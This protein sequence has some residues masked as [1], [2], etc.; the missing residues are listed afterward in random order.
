V[1]IQTIKADKREITGKKSRFL[2]RGGITPANVFGHGIESLALQCD[3]AELQRVLTQAGKT[4][5]IDVDIKSEKKPRK[6][7]IRE[8]QRDALSGQ[9]LHV[10]F[11]QVK[12]TEKMT[13]DIPVVLVGESPAAKSKDNIIEQTLSQIEVSSLPEKIPHR[14]EVDITSLKEA[15]DAIHV[16]DLALD[17]DITINADPDQLLVKVSKIKIAVEK[18]EAVAAPVPEA[19]V[20]TVAEETKEGA[21]AG[22]EKAKE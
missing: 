8:V 18:E 16:S 17:K 4:T 3:T 20:K 9:L 19:E 7:F 22:E 13:A 21:V 6:V 2:R 14:I 12:L 1:A 11:Y 5:L 15:G 10:D